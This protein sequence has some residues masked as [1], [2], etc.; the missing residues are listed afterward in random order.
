MR[1]AQPRSRHGD[2]GQVRSS[3]RGRNEHKRANAPEAI[4]HAVAAKTA[5]HAE[6]KMRAGAIRVLPN[7]ETKKWKANA[8]VCPLNSLNISQHF[9]PL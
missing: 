3:L 4:C 8:G 1:M 5:A 7:R 2:P 9:D 6:R